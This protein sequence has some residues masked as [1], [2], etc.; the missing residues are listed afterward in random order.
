MH[1]VTEVDR[2]MFAYERLGDGQLLDWR[3]FW[4]GRDVLQAG[5]AAPGRPPRPAARLLDRRRA[6]L[7][8]GAR[9]AAGRSTTRAP[10][11]R[12]PGPSTSTSS[13]PAPRP[14]AGP[15]A[16]IAALHPGTEIADRLLGRGGRALAGEAADAERALRRRVAGSRRRRRGHGATG[17]SC[18]T[19]TASC[20]ASCTPRA[21]ATAPDGS[22]P[23]VVRT[24]VT[25]PPRST[26]AEPALRPR[27]LP[28]AARP[29][30]RAQ[31]HHPGVEPH[32]AAGRHGPRHHRAGV[33]G[34][35][36]AHRGGRRSTTARPTRSP[37]PPRSTA[38]TQN[39][40]VSV[41]WN[42]GIRLSS[43]PVVA[44]LNSDCQVEPGWD[45]ALLRGGH[46]RA[47]HRLPVHRPL[48][49]ARVHPSRP[50]RHGGLVLHAHPGRLRRGRARSTSGSARRSARTP[51]TGTAP[52]SWASSCR[53]C[54]RRGW[55]TPAA[56]AAASGHDLLLQAHRYKYGWKHGV[57]PDR[58]PP[59]YDRRSSRTTTRGPAMSPRHLAPYLDLDGL[60]PDPIFVIGSPR[61]G[62]TALAQSLGRHPDLWVGK[63]SYLLHDLSRASGSSRCGS[64]TCSG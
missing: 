63:E 49:R 51:T 47:T 56:P 17:P 13:A 32:A 18:T 37:S 62:T 7:A 9:R 16:A 57:D 38:T 4:E 39:R 45:E 14:R 5:A 20:S 2:L 35:A 29:T 41:G 30:T 6:G 3:G 40:G 12:W 59:Y 54:R 21:S 48:R 34:G 24:P 33:G 44:V 31:R 28:R 58:A 64:A 27:R 60:C 1:F 10:A 50:G 43:A 36:A 22:A 52:G 42:T 8:A 46:V 53:R 15:T 61:S 26:G 11:A 19:P 25:V 55:S 23:A